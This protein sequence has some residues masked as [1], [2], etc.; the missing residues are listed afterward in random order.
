MESATT[1]LGAICCLITGF[2]AWFVAL[3]S[4]VNAYNWVGVGVSPLLQPSHS[5]AWRGRTEAYRETG[6]THTGSR[7]TSR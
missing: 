1:R 4:L 3:L 2:A 6:P 7:P 5:V